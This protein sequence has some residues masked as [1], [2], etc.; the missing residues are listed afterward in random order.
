MATYHWLSS[1]LSSTAFQRN[2]GNLALPTITIP[3][4][5]RLVRF[6]GNDF[7]CHGIASAAGVGSVDNYKLTINIHISSGAYS[8]RDIFNGIYRFNSTTVALYDSATF[9]RVYSQWLQI[10]DQDIRLNQKTSYGG[11]GKAAF[12]IQTNIRI[13]SATSVSVAPLNGQTNVGVQ[14]LYTI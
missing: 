5:G 7:D 6:I 9:E 1:R 4:G 2:V 8:P 3:A 14:Y 13:D 11:P 10:A 12:T